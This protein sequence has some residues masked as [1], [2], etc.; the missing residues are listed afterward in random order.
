M[1]AMQ[2]TVAAIGVLAFFASVAVTAVPS[3]VARWSARARP[4]VLA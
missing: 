1:K 2:A 3:V 4:S